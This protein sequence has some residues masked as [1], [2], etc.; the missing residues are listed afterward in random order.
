MFS[1]LA[2]ALKLSCVNLTHL[3]GGMNSFTSCH[4][5]LGKKGQAKNPSW[6]LYSKTAM[7]YFYLLQLYTS[8]IQSIRFMHLFTLLKTVTLRIVINN[9]KNKPHVGVRLMNTWCTHEWI[10]HLS[11]YVAKS[12]DFTENNMKQY[13]ECWI[14]RFFFLSVAL[15]HSSSA[16]ISQVI[17]KQN[18]LLSSPKWH[19]SIILLL[20]LGFN[21]TLLMYLQTY[22]CKHGKNRVVMY[23]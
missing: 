9:T 17:C 2:K 10:I 14:S 7:R 11:M 8:K 15:S 19:K 16:W 23:F 18:H 21:V 13:I 5:Q 12:Y 1:H 6:I 20:L 3:K 4:T 22:V